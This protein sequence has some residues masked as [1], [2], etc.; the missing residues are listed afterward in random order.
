MAYAIETGFVLQLTFVGD[1][2]GQQV[3]TTFH[4]RYVGAIQADGAA[5][6]YTVAASTAGLGKL[7][8]DWKSAVSVD[9]QNVVVW[10]QWIYP[11]RYRKVIYVPAAQ[12]GALT[13]A[14]TANVAGVITGY[15][16]EANRRGVS[17]KHLPGVPVAEM[18]VGELSLAYK[19]NLG[20]LG[21]EMTRNIVIGA[22][23][24]RPVIYHRAA[25]PDSYVI[26][27]YGV[28][29][30]VRVERRRTLRLGS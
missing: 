19:G 25:P 10:S 16:D 15:A 7:Y 29:P 4:Y 24:L 17:N 26:T 2:F 6:A 27:G 9:V 13:A 21:D 18:A 12:T 14:A 3:M 30:Y 23:A 11:V 28:N 5:Y 1:L 8:D 20:D 22:D